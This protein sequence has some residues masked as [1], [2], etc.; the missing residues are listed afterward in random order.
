MSLDLT[1]AGGPIFASRSRINTDSRDYGAF[2]ASSMQALLE[3]IVDGDPESY[4]HSA[5]AS[6]A[7][8]ETIDASVQLATNQASQQVDFVALQNINLKNFK[9]EYSNDNGVTFAIVPGFDYQVGTADNAL[10]DLIKSFTVITANLFKLTMYRTITPNEEKQ[11]G[12]IYACLSTVQLTTG[13]MD[14]YDKKF[15]EE[16][17]TVRLGDGTRS[18]EVVLRSAVSHDHWGGVINLDL[19]SKAE[20]DLLRT[21]KR[22][23]KA[24]TFVPEPYDVPRDV[25]TTLF[26]GPWSDRYKS[27]FKGAGYEIDFSLEEAGTL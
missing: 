19:V 3:R 4:W 18:D 16:I 9:L 15:R 27:A 12:G 24:F 23:G 21:I 10:T 13:G 11:V 6:D 5:V 14:K 8:T 17:R 1:A 2:A 7:A 22:T 26:K 25:F 20:R